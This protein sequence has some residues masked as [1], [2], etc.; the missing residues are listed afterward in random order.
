MNSNHSEHTYI[1]S[2][3]FTPET[4]L[5]VVWMDGTSS[6]TG[7]GLG[8]LKKK[9]TYVLNIFNEWIKWCTCTYSAFS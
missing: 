5:S 6:G 1:H 4:N 8:E 9:E 7:T 3:K 2:H